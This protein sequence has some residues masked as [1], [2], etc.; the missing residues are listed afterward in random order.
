MRPVLE[1]DALLYSLDDI[2]E[3][4]PPESREEEGTT[5][6]DSSAGKRIRELEE[7]LERVREQFAE[8]RMVVKRCLDNQLSTLGDG[9]SHLISNAA[10]EARARGT[11]K[12]REAEEGYFT[13]YSCSGMFK[14]HAIPEYLMF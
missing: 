11:S 9:S 7:E 14:H 13:S 4:G 3:D 2:S 8:Y 6:P 12:F 10:Q 1:D 5:T